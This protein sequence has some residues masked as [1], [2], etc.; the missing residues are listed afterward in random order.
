[1]PSGRFFS[2]LPRFRVAKPLAKASSFAAHVKIFGSARP[3]GK[4]RGLT[5]VCSRRVPSFREVECGN[6]HHHRK[7]V[8]WRIRKKNCDSVSKAAAVGR[9]RSQSLGQC[10]LQRCRRRPSGRTWCHTRPSSCFERQWSR[11]LRIP[12]PSNRRRRSRGNNLVWYKTAGTVLTR[13]WQAQS[14]A[15]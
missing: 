9:P 5:D 6:C 11:S 12:A 10:H 15:K 14:V 3:C 4:K 1:M 13:C 7:E 8:R 2:I